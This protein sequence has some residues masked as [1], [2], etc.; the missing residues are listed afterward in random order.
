MSDT[1]EFVRKQLEMIPKVLDWLLEDSG[2]QDRLGRLFGSLK[3]N[4]ELSTETIK[5]L[6]ELFLFFTDSPHHTLGNRDVPLERVLCE[7]KE[8]LEYSIQKKKRELAELEGKEI[9][10]E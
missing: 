4:S 8:G 9:E 1:Q 7:A 3:C 10:N 5:I 6:R 2:W